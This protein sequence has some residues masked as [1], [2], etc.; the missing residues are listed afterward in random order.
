[1][2]NPQSV[3]AA[4][5]S[6]VSL[7]CMLNVSG[8]PAAYQWKKEVTVGGQTSYAPIVGA[9][10]PVYSIPALD[11]N[12][13]GNYVLEAITPI[14]VAVSQPAQVGILSVAP[15]FDLTQSPDPVTLNV[16]DALSLSFTPSEG[17]G[18]F[19]YQWR[20]D[21][22]ALA[23]ATQA[24]YALAAA[25]ASAS[26]RYT[27]TVSN[28]LGSA[29]SVAVEVQVGPV[30]TVTGGSLLAWGSNI[31]GQIGD[32]KGIGRTTFVPVDKTGDLAGKTVVQVAA[33][34]SHS[35][36]LTAD[37]KVFAWGANG[38]GQLGN[39]VSGSSAVPVPVNQNGV[40]A[41][42]TVTA[43]AA[44]NLHSLALASDGTVFSWGSNGSGQLG[45]GLGTSST[46]PVA[47][48]TTG[49][50]AGKT[51][52][53]IAAYG[54]F[55][56]ALASDGQVFTWGSN[57]NGQLGNNSGAATSSLPVAVTTTGVLAGKTITSIACGY[58]H[59]VAASSDGQLFAWGQN[60]Y[61]QLGNGGAAATNSAPLAVTMNG[62]LAGRSVASVSA[63][64]YHS[65]AVTTD[66]DA[67]AWGYN[68]SGQMGN[69]GSSTYQTTPGS[70]MPTAV[71]AGKTIA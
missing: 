42:K 9:T 66:G 2:V 50:L 49:S 44:G 61:Y 67:F 12:G 10:G 46:L 63:G 31:N 47:V 58:Y 40:L 33:G 7:S 52:T 30:G 45:N 62:A 21:G 69:G 29:T 54:D 17:S 55:S 3:A 43:I 71:T 23:G 70:I 51:V 13:A 25:P 14:G 19:T 22:V 6:A 68:P 41:G 64:Y 11:A 48:L 24:T 37:G 60:A 35:L 57:S 39:S 26:G 56:A 36:A 16:G 27:L 28:G 38:S 65:L 1:M 4:Q 8:V 34:A 15:A 59:M 5:G 18:P 32:A 20:K 53:K